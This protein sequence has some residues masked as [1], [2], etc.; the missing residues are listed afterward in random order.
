MMT[1]EQAAKAFNKKYPKR[2]IMHAADLDNNRFIVHAQE[3]T[4][5]EDNADPLFY[6]DKKSGKITQIGS[7]IEEIDK[8]NEAFEKRKIK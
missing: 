6:I 8:M 7:T 5:E 1:F 3:N 4:K 2:H